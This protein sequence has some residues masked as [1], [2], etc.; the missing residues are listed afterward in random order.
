MPSEASIDKADIETLL[1]AVGASLETWAN[2]DEIAEAGLAS[3]ATGL[4]GL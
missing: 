1:L 2:E 3:V 4:F